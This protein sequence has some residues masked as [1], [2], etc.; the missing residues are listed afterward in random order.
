VSEVREAPASKRAGE[1]P[2]AELVFVHAGFGARAVP[3]EAAWELQRRT[4]ARR[5]AGEI[6]DTVLLLEHP[7][8]Y[9]AG[10]RTRPLDRPV[11]DPGAPVIDV[12]R[13]GSITWHGPGQLVGYPIVRLREPV[14]VVHFVRKIEDALIG[15]CAEFGL[16]TTRVEGRPGVWVPGVP[17]RKIGAIGLRV[18][19]RVS[20]HGLELNCDC[21]M[22]WFDKMVPCGLSDAG[23]TSLSQELGRPV[24]VAEVTPLMERHL[25]DV[26]GVT[27]TFH[28]TLAQT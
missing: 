16:Q 27:S 25:A 28:R 15:V 23:V 10:K 19:R 8:V 4:H 20:M 5:V 14:D 24:T 17:D 2:A 13:G 9:T 7:P 3:Y 11:G 22:S 18:S 12:D 6:P 26:L 1:R 21:D